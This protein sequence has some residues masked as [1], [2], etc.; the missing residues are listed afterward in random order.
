L[1]K[2]LTPSKISGS[3]HLSIATY[4]LVIKPHQA[5]PLPTR[6]QIRFD[7]P[8]S[9][10]FV[11]T[12]RVPYTVYGQISNVRSFSKL[13]DAVD[14]KQQTS[15]LPHDK[16]IGTYHNI[17]AHAPLIMD[18]SCAIRIV[19]V[20]LLCFGLCYD[21]HRRSYQTNRIR[22]AFHKQLCTQTRY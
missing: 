20:L 11:L 3:M 12:P 21:Y 9:N 5:M 17:S 7:T 18:Q 15:Q 2:P 22:C 19:V 4:T 16:T 10:S 13:T 6:L 1:S 14:S 8:K